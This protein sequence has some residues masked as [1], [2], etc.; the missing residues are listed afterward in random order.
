VWW[1]GGYRINASVCITGQDRAGLERLLRYRA[2]PPFAL[3][4]IAQ[5]PATNGGQQ[6]VYRLPKSQPVVPRAALLPIRSTS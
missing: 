6:V 3:E 5:V 1:G 2:R 4:R